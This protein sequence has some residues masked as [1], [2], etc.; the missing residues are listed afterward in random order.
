MI[1]KA[2]L[3]ISDLGEYICDPCFFNFFIF[4]DLDHQFYL[5]VVLA[6]GIYLQSKIMLILCRLL[7]NNY[8]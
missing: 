8:D 2:S 1:P 7:K 6:Y 5:A 3:F 4:L